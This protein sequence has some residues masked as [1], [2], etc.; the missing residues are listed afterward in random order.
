LVSDFGYPRA[1]RF[2]KTLNEN[3]LWLLPLQTFFKTWFLMHKMGLKLAKNYQ[4]MTFSIFWKK[5]HFLLYFRGGYKRQH[6]RHRN[7]ATKVLHSFLFTRWLPCR[8]IQHLLFIFLVAAFYLVVKY[9]QTAKIW[10]T[11]WFR[12]EMN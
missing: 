5:S 11:V 9:D 8:K 3:R 7:T 6:W 10:S 1:C 4:E 2:I 12:P